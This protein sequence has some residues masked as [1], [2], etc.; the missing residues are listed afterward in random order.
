V[1]RAERLL[2]LIQ[3]LRRHRRPVSGQTLADELGISLRTVYRDIQT[4]IG[5]GAAIDGEAGIGFILR[6]GFVLPPLMFSD[7]EIEA[8]V[9]GLRWVAQRSDETFERAAMDAL[10]KIAAV[11]PDDMRDSIENIG[12]LAAPDDDAV[13]VDL[14]LVRAAIRDEQKLELHYVD[15]DG[16]ETQ[17]VIWPIAIGFFKRAQ[18]IAAWCEMRADYRHFRTDRIVRVRQTGKRYPRRRRLLMKEWRVI[19]GVAEQI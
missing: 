5:Q 13:P 18:V 7:E 16:D 2:G 8:L 1:A 4:L 14:T 17:R 11:L 15:R 3:V 19:E 6:P 12:L 10:A 9:L